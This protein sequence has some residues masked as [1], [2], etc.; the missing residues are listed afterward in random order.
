MLLAL[1]LILGPFLLPRAALACPTGQYLACVGPTIHTGIVNL[2]PVCTCVPNGGTLIHAMQTASNPLPDTLDLFGAVVKGNVSQAYTALGSLAIKNSCPTCA[3]TLDICA[4]ERD[5]EM[6]ENL[7]GRG[8]L[9][10]VTG[11]PELL[12][13]NPG[14]TESD[15]IPLSPPPAGP[16]PPPAPTR[17]VETYI[18]AG[19]SCAIL[20]RAPS[21]MAVM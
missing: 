12:L 7:I 4:N 1:I 3:V 20:H 19:A 18:I 21:S 8:W 17:G 2:D 15:A 16:T 9:A 10:Y 13:V 5:K 14:G 11:T 6:L